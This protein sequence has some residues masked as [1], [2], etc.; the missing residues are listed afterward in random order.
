M[1]VISLALVLIET[2]AISLIPNYGTVYIVYQWPQ[3]WIKPHQSLS[4]HAIASNDLDQLIS[5]LHAQCN[6]ELM[7]YNVTR[8]LLIFVNWPKKWVKAWKL[9][10]KRRKSMT[11]YFKFH[12]YQLEQCIPP[13]LPGIPEISHTRTVE[14]N[15][16]D[17]IKSWVGWKRAHIT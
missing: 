11:V 3:H 8:T 10:P 1:F 7:F 2:F 15:E 13:G 14:S 12:G 5:R 16:A 17:T 9:G 6:L 4:R